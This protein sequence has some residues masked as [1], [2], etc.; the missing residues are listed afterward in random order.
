MVRVPKDGVELQK[1]LIE[2]AHASLANRVALGSRQAGV[3]GD[4]ACLQDA[5]WHRDQHMIRMIAAVV[6]ERIDEIAGEI[7]LPHLMLQQNAGILGQFAGDL[8]VSAGENVAIVAREMQGP[9][10]T[11]EGDLRARAG[12]LVFEIGAGDKGEPPDLLWREIVDLRKGVLHGEE[13]I[14]TPSFCF[15]VINSR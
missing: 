14:S 9:C 8:V 11:R 13:D 10:H 6:G 4:L 3:E 15:W 12:P 5:E 7:D 2:H 1:D